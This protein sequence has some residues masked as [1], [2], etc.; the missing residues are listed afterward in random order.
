MVRVGVRREVVVSAGALASPHLLMLSGV[1]P[2]QH[3]E[4]LKVRSKI[5]AAVPA[6]W[7]KDSI[8]LF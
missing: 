5:V 8:V 2:R 4:Q 6:E 3:L 1:G 7:Y